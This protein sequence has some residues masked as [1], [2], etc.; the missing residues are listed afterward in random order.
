PPHVWLGSIQESPNSMTLQISC[1]G[2]FQNE[3]LSYSLFGH[4]SKTPC[5]FGH[6]ANK[7]D[8][9]NHM[10]FLLTRFLSAL[11]YPIFTTIVSVALGVV[12][13]WRKKR[14][15]GGVFI[16]GGVAYL[17]FFSTTAFST[18]LA[19]GIEKEYGYAEL[20]ESPQADAILVLGGG[21]LQNDIWIELN[22][23]SDRVFNAARLFKAGKAPR[24]I[25]TSGGGFS[26]R[27]HSQ[28]MSSFLEEL[29]V[30]RE[31]II[32]ESQAENTYQHTVYLK[33]I[34]EERGITS[35]ILVTSAW[36]M[37]RSMAVFESNIDGIEITPFAVD[38]LNGKYNTL[39]DYL[40]TAEGLY[41]STKILREYIGFLVYD[42]RGWI[43]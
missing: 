28:A 38:S 43:D 20:S 37:R 3:V 17:Y 21:T 31:N 39:L 12:L 8:R 26:D 33:P 25:V 22:D 9:F 29:G 1:I 11:L 7:F 13:N 18:W 41:K 16:V 24:V 23:S 19:V 30:P 36:H 42:F 14:K 34:F 35:V 40:P 15:L 4:G 32:E 27:P 5:R 6:L 2:L 10:S